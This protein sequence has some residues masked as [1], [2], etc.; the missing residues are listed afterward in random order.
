MLE[1]DRMI[2]CV[3]LVHVILYWFVFF[4]LVLHFFKKIDL[5]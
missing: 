1:L 3:V 4:V 5:D 2:F